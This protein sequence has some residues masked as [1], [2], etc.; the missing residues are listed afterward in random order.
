MEESIL[1]YV[2]KMINGDK[3]RL[4]FKQKTNLDVKTWLNQSQRFITIG[5][6]EIIN[7]DHVI[8]FSRQYES[9]EHPNGQQI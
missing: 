6:D 4:S 2:A 5:D 1:V 9:E 7:L 8:G 3:H